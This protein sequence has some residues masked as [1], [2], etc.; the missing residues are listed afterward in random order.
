MSIFHRPAAIKTTERQWGKERRK[1][2]K[3]KDRE[4][5]N[6]QHTSIST[7][8]QIYKSKKMY[9]SVII[10]SSDAKHRGNKD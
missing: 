10:Y 1:K 2:K 7:T 6:E 3:K 4:K 5:K 8:V 9:L